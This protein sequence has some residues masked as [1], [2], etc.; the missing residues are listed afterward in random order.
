VPTSSRI[1]PFDTARTILVLCILLLHAA[2]AYA[3]TIPWWHAQDLKNW[4]FDL[5][6][7]FLD[8]FTL[9]V[10]FFIA[11]AFARASHD[12][13]GGAGFLRAKLRR[14]GPPLVLLPTFYLPAMVYM[15]YLRRAE[16]PVSFFAYWVRWMASAT[17]WSFSLLTSM[18]TAARYQDAFSPH[19]LWFLSML[20]VFFAGYALWRTRFSD[21]GE[22]R[23]SAATLA[24]AGACLA[25]GYAAANLLIQDWAWARLGPFLLFQ[26]ARVPIYLGAFLFGA[27]ARPHLFR[28]RPLPGSPWLWLGALLPLFAALVAVSGGA[29]AMAPPSLPKAMASGL[30]RAG[31]VV[32]AICLFINLGFRFWNRADGWLRS[33]N[34]SSYD[35]YLLHMP[36]AVFVQAA[37]VGLALP[38]VLKLLLA[39]LVPACVCWG[40][41]RGVLARRN[42][43]PGLG[44]LLAFFAGFSLLY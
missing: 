29:P 9:P 8:S 44:L 37:L 39:F 24:A 16:H 41:S 35:L 3:F 25:A 2:C 5:L 36:L 21:D 28:R 23:V 38:L 11:G 18:E 31:L 33:L 17:D 43:A 4:G 1:T 20:L 13:H 27:Y 6:L 42:P 22:R 12:R 19:H 32:S 14:F 15:G 30:I 34:A 10:L 26:P 7:F 40:L